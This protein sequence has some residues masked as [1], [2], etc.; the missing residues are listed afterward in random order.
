[1]SDF[2]LVKAHAEAA[3]ITRVYSTGKVPSSPVAPYVVIDLDT[4]TPGA[5]RLAAD[6]L[7]HRIICQVFG[8][9]RESVNAVAGQLDDAFR[10]RTLSDLPGAPFSRREL[11]GQLVRDQP[12]DL[13]GLIHTYRY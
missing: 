11:A 10:N 2:D 5:A 9:T 7:W 8:Q 1:M 13:L 12:G 3:G 6:N 4:G